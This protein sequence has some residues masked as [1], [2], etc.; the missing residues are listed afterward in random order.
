MT[1]QTLAR[2]TLDDLMGVEGKAELIGGVIVKFMGTGLW[3]G[4]V[5]MRIAQSLVEYGMRTGR[6]F[7]TPDG[8]SY[9]VPEL[10]SERESFGPDAAY[11]SG[12]LPA[13]MMRFVEGAPT[14]A[15]EVRSENDYGPAPERAMAAKR[16]DYFEAGTLVV[17]DVD[18][19]AKTARAYAA[20]DPATPRAFAATDTADAEPHLPGW[21]LP[22]AGVFA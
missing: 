12:P 6:G 17:W 8:V 21:R 9:A 3:P 13:N 22:L 20:T 7:G 4:W 15:V 19:I 14:L 16:A 2:A 11:R 1:L 5:S 18:P 10:S